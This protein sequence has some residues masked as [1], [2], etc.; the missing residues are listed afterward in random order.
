MNKKYK[1]KLKSKSNK[2][3]KLYSKIKEINHKSNQLVNDMKPSS[4]SDSDDIVDIN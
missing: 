3:K 2:Y 4:S 1:K